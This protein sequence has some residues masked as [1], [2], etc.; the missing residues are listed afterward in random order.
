MA[1]I[2]KLPKEEQAAILAKREYY[3]KWRAKNKDKVKEH[4]R[5]Y[6]IKKAQSAVKKN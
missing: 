4:S 6:W 5:R 1:D 3:K 2:S